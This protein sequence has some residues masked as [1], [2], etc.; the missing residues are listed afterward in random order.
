MYIHY[1]FIVHLFSSE[2]ERCFK[3]EIEIK[4]T[5]S[6]FMCFFFSFWLFILYFKFQSPKIVGKRDRERT[7]FFFSSNFYKYGL[8]IKI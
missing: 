4:I 3:I 5:S 2:D 1:Y 6:L 7:L 8:K